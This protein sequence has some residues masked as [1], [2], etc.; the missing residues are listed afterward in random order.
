M[1]CPK[2]NNDIPDDSKFCQYCGNKLEIITYDSNKDLEDKL[3]IILISVA[4]LLLILGCIIAN[5]SNSENNSYTQRITHAQQK[6]EYKPVLQVQNTQFCYDEW[7]SKYVCGTVVNNSPYFYDFVM[8][9]IS[10]FDNQGYTLGDTLAT[11]SLGANAKW[12]FKA[13]VLYQNVS[14]FSV[15]GIDY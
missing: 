9:N 1:K 11:S 6:A 2:C 15:T 4:I 10:L 13:P 3:P 14:S 5:N 8:V 7:G 12:K